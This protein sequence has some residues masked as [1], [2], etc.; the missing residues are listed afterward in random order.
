M[1]S[2]FY[3][4]ILLIASIVVIGFIGLATYS[5]LS[6]EWKQHQAEYKDYVV[7][8]A[9]D[10]A[11]KKRAAKIETGV[12]QIFIGS[13]KKADRCMSCHIGVENPMMTKVDQPYKVHSGDYLTNHPVSKFGC[14][15]CHYGQGRATNKKEAHGGSRGVSHWDYPIIPKKYAQSACA[16]CHD[17]KMLADE[18][19]ENIVKGEELFR[20]K[21]CRG[22]HKLNGVGGDLG[23]ALDGIGSQAL[24]YFP[25]GHL[26]GE[27]TAYNWVKQHFD[28][29][30]SIVPTSEMKVSL[31]DE[32]ADQ[33][34]TYIF[35]IRADEVPSKYKLIKNLPD[36]NKDGEELF[37]MYCSACHGDGTQS[38]YEEVF[39]RT[40]PAINNP[41]F[42]RNIEDTTLK[43]IID[44]GRP[45]TQ[46]TAWKHN[47]SGVKKEEIDKILSYMTK[48]RANQVI[49]PFNFVQFKSDVEKGKQVYS[50][51]CA[52][53]HGEDGKGG[54]RKLGLN[55]RNKTVQTLVS[56]E[57]LARTVRD[58]RK[59]TP[60]PSFGAD[61]E[62]LTDQEIAD[63]VGYVKTLA[64][65]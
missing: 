28:D 40:V 58:G 15:I 41:D 3:L 38:I 17:F 14:T 51:R 44:E 26:V 48:N 25:M 1:H 27:L 59:N 9:K 20:E 4:S 22:C 46:M 57:F 12:Q 7:K 64:K 18:G 36:T 19:M 8:H 34:T 42:L 11:A 56:P 21:G 30:R 35:S 43:S 45:G 53:C 54:G 2:R 63:V 60:M 23:K 47:A 52:F 32:E 39:G 10:E 6:S 5:E 55:L 37:K 33:L 29:P 50:K 16:R 61:G 62:G 24:H 31:K 13:L 49:Q 65:K